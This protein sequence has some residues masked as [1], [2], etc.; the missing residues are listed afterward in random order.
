MHFQ[1][2]IRNR[3]SELSDFN[4]S[5]RSLLLAKNCNPD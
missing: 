3:G 5:D 1:V 2:E 4:E